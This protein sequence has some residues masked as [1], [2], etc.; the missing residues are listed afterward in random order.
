MAL[1]S[2]GCPSHVAPLPDGVETAVTPS[3]S[4]LLHQQW[5][6]FR[7]N[8]VGG[9]HMKLGLAE[10]R[11]RK[12]NADSQKKQ[13]KKR[14]RRPDKEEVVG[15]E[16]EVHLRGDVP[17]GEEGA[18]PDD[19]RA[20]AEELPPGGGVR[21]APDDRTTE[22]K[23]SRTLRSGETVRH[24]QTYTI[25]LA[26]VAFDSVAVSG[27]ANVPESEVST[28]ADDYSSENLDSLDLCLDR[29]VNQQVNG[30]HVRT[31]NLMTSS[32]DFI[33][34]VSQDELCPEEVET[35]HQM[36]KQAK[37]ADME[38]ELAGNQTQTVEELSRELGEIRAS[39]GTEGIHQNGVIDQSESS[40][41]QSRVI[42][43][44]SQFNRPFYTLAFSFCS[45]RTFEAALKQR[46]GIITQLTSNLQQAR[47]EKDDI[48][49][50]FLE[51]TEQSHKLHIQFQQLQAGETLRNATHSST[52]ADLLQ[53]RQQIAQYQQQLDD[54]GA[55]VRSGEEHLLTASQ[56][57]HKLSQ[58][59][60]AGRS[61]E[62]TFAQKLSEKDLVIAEQ[63]H[64]I[65][66]QE[67]SL[68]DLRS[69]LALST[70]ASEESLA[71]AQRD[72]DLL[73][74]EHNAIISEHER[75]LSLLRDELAQV[76]R[77]ASQADV[78]RG[79]E[80]DA[81]I[82]EQA[83][84]KSSEKRLEELCF[85]KDQ[86]LEKHQEELENTRVD[87][88]RLKGELEGSQLE[89]ENKMRELESCKDQLL[90]SKVEME[91]E[92]MALS[93]CKQELEIS[94]LELEKGA[95]ELES[96]TEELATSRQKERTSSGEIMQLMGTVE[97]LQKRCHQ[98][99][100]SEGD[101]VQRMEEES[102]RKLECLRAELDEMYGEQI[103][104]MKRELNLQH[105]TAV[106]RLTQEHG[107]ELEA[108]RV[109]EERRCSVVDDL[110]AKL[111]ELQDALQESQAMHGRAKDELGGLAQEKSSL[112]AQVEELLQDLRLAKDA[113]ENNLALGK[114]SRQT[115]LQHLQRIT[116]G[117][118]SQLEAAEEAALE[119][120]AKHES[121]V[122]NYKIKLEMLEREKDAVL[123]RMA[124]SQEAELERLRTQL[125]FS[126]EE[127]LI[128]L[129][130]DLQRESFLNAENL[131]DE[132]SI[133]RERAL[134]ELRATY[135]DKLGSLG[136]EKAA[137]AT[138]RGE[139]LEQIL[140][141][142]EDLKMASSSSRAEELVQQL[143]ELQAEV[144]E[145]RK[146]AEER[147]K[148]ERDYK[149]LLTK[150]QTL[151]NEAR[152][153]DDG[154]KYKLEEQDNQKVQELA[155]LR[156]EIE[157]QRTTFSFAEKN[158]E[159]N[160]QELKGE[161][162]C[163]VQAKKQL[164]ERTL[165]ET[166]EFETKIASLQSQVLELEEKEESGRRVKME[167]DG[168][169]GDRA[170]A[171]R[172]KDTTDL[173][174]KLCVISNEKESL[175][176]RLSDVTDKLSSSE[177]KL[178]RL[179]GELLEIHQEHGKVIARN[180]SLATELQRER[181]AAAE[182]KREGDPR[183]RAK[184]QHRA[185]A[186]SE[187]AAASVAD[188]QRQIE[189]LQGE[190]EALRCRL[191]AAE[192]ERAPPTLQRLLPLQAAF[193][194]GDGPPP[195]PQKPPAAPASGLGS[196]RR[197]RRQRSKQERKTT[198]S[199]ASTDG[200][201]REER[202]RG[203]EEEEEEEEQQELSLA[204]VE[205]GR[206]A[207]QAVGAGMESE[208]ASRSNQRRGSGE[209]FADRHQGDG[210]NSSTP[211]GADTPL[212]S[213]LLQS[214]IGFSSPHPP[215][216]PHPTHPLIFPVRSKAGPK[217]AVV[218]G[219]AAS[220]ERESVAQH[221][222][223]RLQLEA[224]RLSLTQI[225][226]AQLELLGEQAAAHQASSQ[227]TRLGGLKGHHAQDLADRQ[228]PP[229]SRSGEMEG[230]EELERLHS[231]YQQ[232][233]SAAEERHATQLAA[234]E[235]RLHQ[236]TSTHRIQAG[237][238][239]LPV[240]RTVLLSENQHGTESGAESASARSSGHL[241]TQLPAPRKALHHKYL[242]EVAADSAP[243]DGA[244]ETA[245]GVRTS[246]EE[247]RYGERVEEEVA[248]FRCRWSSPSSRSWHA[249][250]SGSRQTTSSM[251]TH[252][253]EK[254]EAE[255][256]EEE[257]KERE[258]PW[259]G[260]RDLGSS[261]VQTHP[262]EEKKKKK[263]KKKEEEDKE[264]ME[265]RETSSWKGVEGR[266]KL[267]TEVRELTSEVIRLKEQ[268]RDA[269]SAAQ[270]ATFSFFL[271]LR[272]EVRYNV[273]LGACD[274]RGYLC[275]SDCISAPPSEELCACRS[276]HR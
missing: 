220:G 217:P 37:M 218:P 250:A 75:S 241:T 94:K 143:Q 239:A 112:Q 171:L 258:T 159:V 69:Q 84:L 188:H 90:N 109:Q 79:D 116:D 203:G 34:Y 59:E 185:P 6:R 127:E 74:S 60:T 32:E 66:G 129:R 163:L 157:K 134:E 4:R 240:S 96:R 131:L 102:L 11:Q 5:R 161:Y 67:Q 244:G 89:L 122:T 119:T 249:S 23:F 27:Q 111:N 85:T 58:V 142:K 227:E 81:L 97:D 25:E 7:L 238:L 76:A 140:A 169:H 47:V 108:L 232:L 114:G 106:E 168:G 263:K 1:D 124:E 149:T 228:P 195:P 36:A 46:D 15:E 255:E 101:A 165:K 35:L 98:G 224:Q 254:E 268:L 10:Y 135:E 253:E 105:A 80:K 16:E 190:V 160:Y 56:L 64:L 214:F 133:K 22:L 29:V 173:M 40:I 130:E 208:V 174:E 123:D 251:Q 44:L 110:T 194:A 206:A 21:G 71:H 49:R 115:E 113:A 245:A 136:K 41:Q 201:S 166:L 181:E 202:Q 216:P 246:P 257:E 209:G 219:E 215:P 199:T 48:M 38:D 154:W 193:P 269:A 54:L 12:A 62:E 53:A 247:K 204:E 274:H 55:Q 189:S 17:E 164:E 146:G 82:A 28:T 152:E 125:L 242:Q 20:P 151:E 176:A 237:W 183:R 191:Q 256:E 276:L 180:N 197:K 229:M 155:E 51:M 2:R 77:R 261:S 50:E 137:F 107:A 145:L 271:P 196:S 86:Q 70:R 92:Q 8:I 118:R 264:V 100:V 132:A 87:L 68:A 187:P 212:L 18:G 248:K 233:A 78:Q 156:E 150:I 83:A 170:A 104:Q 139:L 223:C 153:K 243:G 52:A 117:L 121:E 198:A 221:G 265:K 24:D 42:T 211:V 126:H 138:E 178:E 231:H 267:E 95:R 205:A 148:M 270:K 222:E 144:V 186:T 19:Q 45:C 3:L 99:S 93:S 30:C 120:E 259:I 128:L 91:K 57:E 230:G 33:W 234:L 273:T 262:K 72:K 200:S 226:A 210:G 43:E 177:G 141:L 65:S 235:Q 252:P 158:F 184:P 39:F 266:E 103:V 175:I 260:S 213:L 182:L 236:L 172:E 272:C 225:H 192:A 207:E 275:L 147:A 63:E 31:V 162:T 167:E 13:K 179:K 73:I 26:R 9:G 14:K 61:S 88:E